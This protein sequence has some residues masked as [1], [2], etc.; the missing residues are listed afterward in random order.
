MAVQYGKLSPMDEKTLQ[1]LEYPTIL[2]QLSERCHF[3]PAV[4]QALTLRP[5]VDLDTIRRL[6]GETAGAVRLLDD[7][8]GFTV[9]GARDLRPIVEDA[10]KGILLDPP[11]LLNVKYTLI[12]GRE[13]GRFLEKREGTYP[14][15]EKL[16]EGL[17]GSTGL[18][19]RI[20]QVISDQEEVLDS[21]SPRLGQIRRDLK[22]QHNRLRERMDAMLQ[23]PAVAKHL[24][25]GIITQRGGR[26]V[27]PVRADAKNKIPGIVHDQSAS[28]ATLYIE[29]Q[30]MV[31]INNR[32]RQL[33]LEERDEVRRVLTEC[34]RL[35]AE[36]AEP[37]RSLVEV[38]V[39]FDLALARGRYAEAQGA[40]QP[41]LHPFPRRMSDRHPGVVLRLFSARHPL[42]DPDQVVPIDVAL[43]EQTYA[44]IITGPNTGG[45]TVTLKTVGLLALMAQSGLHIPCASGSALSLFSNV[46]ADI[47][48]EQS[49]EQSL[50]TFSSHIT[51]IIAILERADRRS[52]VILDELGAGTDPQEGAALA[53]ALMTSLLE[54]G[55]T[56]LV[57]THHPDLKAYAHSAPGVVNASVE[58]DIESLQPTYHLTVGL[59]GRSNALAIARRLGLAE[60][61]IETAKTSL[62]PADLQADDLLDEIRRQR[63]L[64]QE[65]RE[66]AERGRQ[67]AEQLRDQLADRL[68]EIEEERLDALEE[69]RRKSREEVRSLKDE[70]QRIREELSR[71]A[72]PK[73]ALEDLEEKIEQVEEEVSRPVVRRRPE[74]LPGPSRPIAEGDRV[75]IRSL[76]REGV[77]QNLDG[78]DAEVQMGPIRVRAKLA[79][80]RHAG[81]QQQAEKAEERSSSTIRV[82]KDVSSPGTELDLRGQRVDEALTNLE[83]FLDK[84][85]IA[86]LP[87]VRIIHGMGSGRLRSAVRR[88]VKSHPQVVQYEPG[89]EGEGGDG[90]TVITLQ[91]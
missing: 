56:T 31:E 32:Y 8:P 58:F 66:A 88:A 73:R 6:Q 7:H 46:F 80:L 72:E 53:R 61:I 25:E 40:V 45:K 10:G 15:L 44:L 39:K 19:S 68:E 74:P 5:L 55:I 2:K 90:V 33:E 38:L 29:P 81:G 21:A 54:R 30:K 26:Y 12:A 41:E 34:T 47:G 51:T 75:V 60:D 42:L 84:A 67:E 27:L 23:N 70:L 50:S 57:T 1:I 49:I 87:Y 48:D 78:E 17:P 63:R 91:E 52:L 79:D 65:A 69:A 4:E 85:F 83:Y 64:S 71:Q 24:Q 43:D 37:L 22:I 35:V 36:Q 20:T 77:V 86:G 14:L 59:P 28:G 89:R 13:L 11:R 82:P 16:V 18:I 9:G 3:Q 62:D 76:D